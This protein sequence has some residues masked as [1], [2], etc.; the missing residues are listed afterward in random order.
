MFEIRVQWI[1]AGLLAA[2][3]S[4]SRS[5]FLDFALNH[6]SV[7][8]SGTCRGK[9][10]IVWTRCFGKEHAS[11]YDRIKVCNQL[12]STLQMLGAEQMVVGHTPQVPLLLVS[13]SWPRQNTEGTRK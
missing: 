9:D 8:K 11:L 4:V 7:L 6:L 10:G 3:C 13:I 12:K 1:L 5:L 2:A